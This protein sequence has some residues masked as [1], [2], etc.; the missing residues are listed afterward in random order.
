MNSLI[1]TLQLLLILPTLTLAVM[2]WRTSRRLRSRHHGMVA[3]ACLLGVA[4]V[5][6]ALFS[7][8]FIFNSEDPVDPGLSFVPPLLTLGL[9][10][11]V[12]RRGLSASRRRALR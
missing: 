2:S 4:A 6:L 11:W 3:F 7:L 8:A 12:V 1:T 9:C 5:V 10:A